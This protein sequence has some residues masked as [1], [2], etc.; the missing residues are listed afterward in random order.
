MGKGAE[1][2]SDFL[3]STRTVIGTASWSRTRRDN[4]NRGTR[5]CQAA[6]VAAGAHAKESAEEVNLLGHLARPD[7]GD[8][9]R[10]MAGMSVKAYFPTQPTH[11]TRKTT[12]RRATTKMGTPVTKM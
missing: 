4:L 5:S 9:A 11:L 12:E 2:G 10:R 8:A 3:T 6:R 1:S 7:I